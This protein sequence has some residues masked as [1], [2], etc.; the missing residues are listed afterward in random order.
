MNHELQVF[1]DA[2]AE[3]PKDWSRLR[4]LATAYVAA[5]RPSLT[6]QFAKLTREDLVALVGIARKQGNWE[7]KWA[8]EAWLLDQYEPQV[9]VGSGF[10]GT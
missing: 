5:N 6:A 3:S 10:G 9:I 1:A 8:A 7:G 2:W 4:G